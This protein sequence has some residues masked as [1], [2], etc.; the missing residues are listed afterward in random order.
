MHLL[1]FRA[2]VPH[3]SADST[4]KKLA[5]IGDRFLHE[6]MRRG[7]TREIRNSPTPKRIMEGPGRNEKVCAI[8]SPITLIKPPKMLDVIR[9]IFLLVATF[10]EIEAGMMV[11]A[12][13]SKVP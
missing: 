13:I 5:R 10:F 12:P 11:S 2:T 7:S 1:S 4:L 9:N 6:R 3:Q 8:K